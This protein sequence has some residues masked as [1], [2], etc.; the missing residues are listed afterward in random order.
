MTSL[1]SA[2]QRKRTRVQGLSSLLP[3]AY[4]LPLLG[5]GERGCLVTVLEQ[6]LPVEGGGDRLR[7]DL[8]P[9]ELFTGVPIRRQVISCIDA[10]CVV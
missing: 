3:P 6:T 2:C 8:S 10:V 9:A 7:L 1:L 4:P 5:Q